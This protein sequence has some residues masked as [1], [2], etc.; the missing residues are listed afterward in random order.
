MSEF[1]VDVPKLRS[2]AAEI[3]AV[4]KELESGIAEIS[5]GGVK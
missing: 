4:A 1:W 5:R 3:E 2:T